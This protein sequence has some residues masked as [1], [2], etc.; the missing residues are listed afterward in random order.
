MSFTTNTSTHISLDNGHERLDR[1]TLEKWVRLLIQG[2]GS[3]AVVEGLK[4]SLLPLGQFI[5]APLHANESYYRNKLIVMPDL[6]VMVASWKQNEECLPHDHGT[7]NGFVLA[8]HGRFIETGYSWNGLQLEPYDRNM[9]YASGDL[10]SVK[11]GDIHSMRCLDRDG[12]TLHI[13]HPPV[14]RM[15]VYDLNNKTTYTVSDQTGAW[16]PQN[17]R[18]ILNQQK[19]PVHSPTAEALRKECDLILYTTLY[20][21]GGLKFE[22]AAQTKARELNAVGQRPV[23]CRKIESKNE[24]LQ[25]FEELKQSGNTVR[26]VHFY[27]HSGMYGIM[28]GSVQ[29]PEQFSPYEWKNMEL[30]ISD[31]SEFYF[32]ACRSGRWFA[33]FIARTLK[34]KAHGYHNYTTVSLSPHR[35]VWEKIKPWQQENLY[36]IACPGKKSHGTIGS[37][38]K[39][40]QLCPADPMDVYQPASDN[41]D[42]TYDSVAQMYEDTFQ[43]IQVRSD[44][45][46]W[47]EQKMKA[48][49]PQRVLDI[50]CGNGAFLNQLSELFT[51]GVG[52]DLSQG[53]IDQARV[54]RRE[55]PKLSFEKID[56]PHLP[57][58]DNS[59]DVVMSTLSFRYLDWD[60]CMKEI[61][62][63]LKPGGR[64]LVL[65]MVAAPVSTGEIP[66]FI[67][68]KSRQTWQNWTQKGFSKNLKKMVSSAAWKKMLAYNPIRS[69]HEMKW[70]LESRFQGHKVELLN[71]GWN[72]RI[73]AFDTGPVQSK[74]VEKLS[75]P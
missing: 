55:N 29:W 2:D 14:H 9:N 38:Q 30:P 45:L 49:Q 4:K 31:N 28:F 71:V 10:M 21:G 22:K 46:I 11:D 66:L 68:S 44:E 12:L 52:V 19:W 25:V 59:F 3:Q 17:T 75:Y 32:H 70:Y 37:L 39:Y 61:L 67:K 62:R 53:M 34:V 48:I 18:E 16:V 57:F 54:H 69:E 40:S 51:E 1:A 26:Q 24:F 58:D 65:D 72:S 56:G 50:G 43:N 47:L 15:K 35:F 74:T 7:S 73:I 5:R 36:I 63:V 64:F 20:R 41:I 33:P 23:V 27:G 6:E 42:T 60:P 13:Y 8:L